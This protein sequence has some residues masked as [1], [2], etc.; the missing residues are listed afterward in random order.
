[1]SVELSNIALSSAFAYAGAAALGMNPLALAV[2]VAAGR[3]FE[4]VGK[5]LAEN[6]SKT[7]FGKQIIQPGAALVATLLGCYIGNSINTVYRIG[8]MVLPLLAESFLATKV[9]SYCATALQTLLLG[10]SGSGK[11]AS[12][13]ATRLAV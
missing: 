5:E 7:Q 12:G 6:A 13:T 4:L 9:S 1:M 2:S 8:K 11:V 10:K 3:A